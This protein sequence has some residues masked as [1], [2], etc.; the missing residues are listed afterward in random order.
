M[1]DIVNAWQCIGCGRI[2]APQPCIG[3][4]QDRKV[5]F[6]YVDDY[7]EA[8]Q[9]AQAAIESADA[10]KALVRQIALTTP[11]NGEWESCY[12]ALQGQARRALGAL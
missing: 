2:E 10:L 3:I 4:C 8:V 1:P 7:A 12:R 9:Q 6:V 11:R 5:Q